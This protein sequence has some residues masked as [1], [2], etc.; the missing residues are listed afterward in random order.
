MENLEPGQKETITRVLTVWWSPW[1]MPC[2]QQTQAKSL[3][4]KGCAGCN[5]SRKKGVC[6]CVCVCV[7]VRERQTDR[8]TDSVWRGRENTDRKANG[9]SDVKM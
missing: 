9:V 2:T 4:W 8:Q 5:L 6:V 7:C 3:G 1:R